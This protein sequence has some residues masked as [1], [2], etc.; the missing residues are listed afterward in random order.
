MYLYYLKCQLS[1][2]DKCL[3]DY[4]INS[5]A[6][7]PFIEYLLIIQYTIIY[8]IKDISFRRVLFS[9]TVNWLAYT[10]EN[11]SVPTLSGYF[12]GIRS[13]FFKKYP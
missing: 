13:L 10:Q 11:K 1:N 8:I 3:L 2:K 12:S 6:L 7:C 4:E 5:L 9:D